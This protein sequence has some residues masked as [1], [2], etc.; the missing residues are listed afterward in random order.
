M[1]WSGWA[2]LFRK[3]VKSIDALF[4]SDY[5]TRP[6]DLSS[7]LSCT[8][9]RVKIPI[10]P[11]SA[12]AWERR[13]D[14]AEQAQISCL[15]KGGGNKADLRKTDFLGMIQSSKDWHDPSTSVWMSTWVALCGG[16]GVWFFT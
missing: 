5:Q 2:L 14:S 4:L 3:R 15:R 8:L 1:L 13:G 16:D 6:C 10:S 12:E 11:P 7:Y 9:C